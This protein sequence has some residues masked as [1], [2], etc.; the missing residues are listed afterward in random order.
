M[1][2]PFR[3]RALELETEPEP[4]ANEEMSV[5]GG[6]NSFSI[7]ISMWGCSSSSSS[8]IDCRWGKVGELGFRVG[9]VGDK[10]EKREKIG[11]WRNEGRI[12][13]LKLRFGVLGFRGR[14]NLVWSLGRW[15]RIILFLRS[16][17]VLYWVFSLVFSGEDEDEENGERLRG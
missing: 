15:E 10:E 17:Y 3:I 8:L 4:E 12:D 7:E 1:L 13:G 11:K 9:R 14:R 5:S 2:D 6:T 16:C